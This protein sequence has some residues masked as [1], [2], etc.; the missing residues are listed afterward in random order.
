[1]VVDKLLPHTQC[2]RHTVILV[3]LRLLQ[4]FQSVFQTLQ[5]FYGKILAFDRLYDC[6]HY[7]LANIIWTVHI[8]EI[9]VMLIFYEMV[10]EAFKY[11]EQDSYSFGIVALT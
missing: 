9:V 8:I 10:G 3:C 11:F 4:L 7:V 1:M 5:F 6:L 2:I